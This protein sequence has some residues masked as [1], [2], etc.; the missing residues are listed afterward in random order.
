MPNPEI[1]RFIT[2]YVVP[3]DRLRFSCTLSTGDTSIFWVTQRL[4]N[5]LAKALLDW[6]DKTVPDERFADFTHRAA[7]QSAAARKPQ[8]EPLKIPEGA[9]WLVDAIDL[10]QTDKGIMLTFKD[11]S[12]EKALNL[13]FDPEHLRRWIK[14]LH[15]QFARSGWPMDLWPE[16]IAEAEDAPPTAQPGLLH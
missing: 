8:G 6:L 9:G 7:Q 12:G 2:A 4:A 10:K 1:H 13:R 5:P 16:W 11:A 14:V 3:E 15:A